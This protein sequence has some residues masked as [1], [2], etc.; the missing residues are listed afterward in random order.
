MPA[1]Q[2]FVF[3]HT[4][5]TET[6]DVLAYMTRQLIKSCSVGP[7]GASSKSFMNLDTD[8]NIEET[9]DGNFII[10]QSIFFFSYFK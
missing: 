10:A 4:G 9:E 1:N 6:R 2:E 8:V 5:D 3:V 7:G